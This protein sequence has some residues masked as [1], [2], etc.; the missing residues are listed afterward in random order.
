MGFE[1]LRIRP[2]RS[3]LQG[4]LAIGTTVLI[5]L[6]SFFIFLF[7]PARLERQAE[8]AF[9]DKAT[10][11]AETMAYAV[12]PALVFEDFQTL[13]EYLRDVGG[14]PDV[15]YVVV[16]DAAGDVV[17]ALNRER[18]ER[19]ALSAPAD[20]GPIPK[21]GALVRAASPVKYDEAVIGQLHL[22]LSLSALRQEVRSSRA[23]I[24][25]ISFLIFLIGLLG[26]V[27]MAARLTGPLA[28]IARTFDEIAGGD[29]SKRAAVTTGDEVGDLARS[30]NLM[31]DQL[32]TAHD[33]LRNI[34]VDLEQRVADRTSELQLEVEVRRRAEEA[35]RASEERFRAMFRSAGMG[36]VLLDR[37]WRLHKSNPAM[38]RLLDFEEGELLDH[39]LSEFLHEDDRPV[40]EGLFG[41][42]VDGRRDHFDVETSY[43]QKNREPRWCRLTVSSIPSGNGKPQFAIGV[44]EDITQRKRLEEELQ[45]AQKRALAREKDERKRAEML[46]EKLSHIPRLNPQ[47]VI[48]LSVDGTV[49]YLNEVAEA[50]VGSAEELE[51][52]AILPA[53]VAAIVRE[54]LSSGRTY[55]GFEVT[56]GRRTLTWSFY[57]LATDQVVYGYGFDITERLELETQLREAQKLEAV[58]RLAGGVA[59]DFNNVLMAITGLSGML[60]EDLPAS[61]PMRDDVEQ[62]QKAADRAASLTRQ[63]LA[64]SR[65]QMLQPTEMNLNVAITDMERMLRRLIGEDV[66]LVTVLE[67]D[68]WTVKADPGQ[69]EQV[70]MNLVVNARDAMP[71]GGR[72][73]ISTRN[74]AIDEGAA[75]DLDCR[76]G[77]YC[78]LRVSDTGMGMAENI[79]S[80]VFEPFFTTKEMGKGTGLGLSTVYGIV[81]QSGGSITVESEPGEGTTFTILL[82]KVDPRA[83]E[84]K[85]GTA[86]ANPLRGSETI[87]L[88]EDEDTVRELASRALRKKGYSVLEAGN[89]AEALE[90]S[91]RFND[92]I[93]LV[94][95]DVVMPR[96][97]GRE[98]VERL[99]MLRPETKVIFMTGY[100][101]DAILHH[102]V[103]DSG[104][105][106]IQKPFKPAVLLNKIREVLSGDPAALATRP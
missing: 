92:K 33:S 11:I 13:D 68:V 99:S 29:L 36:I 20:E 78:M 41:E 103:L 62:I 95:T 49:T 22:G 56:V 72:V 25:V 32:Q 82:P 80:R 23:S 51:P 43:L 57:P 88:V 84:P 91:E 79:R 3:T 40:V 70:L 106:L 86:G 30:F 8:R 90:L 64:F 89:G 44:V 53:D 71:E 63:L 85:I 100:T 98:L 101:D 75:R 87:L 73:T 67:Q 83:E 60:L 7:F 24:A 47:P 50:L 42:L 66:E 39:R 9:L 15:M 38:Q 65:K 102:G 31:V 16:L 37:D 54:S 28:Q 77:D 26:A 94:V 5:G 17:G 74:V 55:S 93:D 48:E 46:A 1:H 6:I 104:I 18:A 27:A 58:G 96:M 14:N 45:T 76:I 52:S 35:F 61:D 59:H 69:I 21:G 34:N 97:S 81:K 2:T 12:S 19:F 4:K 10:R 105:E